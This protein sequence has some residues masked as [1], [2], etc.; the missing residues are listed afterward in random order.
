MEV[1][2][3]LYTKGFISYPR[4][5]TDQFDPGMDLRALCQKQTQSHQWGPFAQQLVDGA[6]EQPRN[7]RNNDKAHPPIHP[8][9]FVTPDALDNHNERRVFEFVTRRFLACCSSDA[10]GESTTVHLS[11]GPEEFHANGLVVIARNY[12]DVY[13]YDKWESS[14]VLPVFTSGEEFVPTEALMTDGK[15]SA[16]GYLTEPELIAL[17][18]VNGIGTDAT[19]A[20]HIAKIKEREYVFT[21]VKTGAG[22]RG[23]A[24][25]GRGRGRGKRGRGGCDDGGGSGKTGVEEFVP[26]SL[27][28]ALVEGYD[29]IGFDNSVTKPFLRKEA[30]CYLVWDTG[31]C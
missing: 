11:Y 23:G 19:M 29:Q 13:P 25:T 22:A 15:T 26:S 21:R 14:Q 27:G 16:P 10:I 30:S 24:T 8:V 1:A 20:E 6:F 28:I 7:G 5:E 31:L 4:T 2:E 18:D 3:K 9:T 12:L 17:M